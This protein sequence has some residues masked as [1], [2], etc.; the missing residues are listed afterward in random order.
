MS[1]KNEQ[2]LCIQIKIKVKENDHTT[3][4]IQEI[5]PTEKCLP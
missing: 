1:D 5:S 2:K 4:F 3:F